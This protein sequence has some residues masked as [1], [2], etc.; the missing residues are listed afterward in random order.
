MPEMQD[1]MMAVSIILMPTMIAVLF[2][3]RT[4]GHRRTTKDHGTDWPASREAGEI[5]HKP[6]V[7]TRGEMYLDLFADWCLCRDTE[8]LRK[9]AQEANK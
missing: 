6:Y 7:Y 4:T 1:W 3:I 9:E 8:A 5:V 2:G